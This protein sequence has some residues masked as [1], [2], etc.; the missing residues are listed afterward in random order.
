M[1]EPVHVNTI[2]SVSSSSPEPILTELPLVIVNRKGYHALQRQLKEHGQ[3]DVAYAVGV[4]ARQAQ[5]I[6]CFGGYYLPFT[7]REAL[8]A[9]CQSQGIPPELVIFLYRSN[10]LDFPHPDEPAS[11]TFDPGYRGKV[12][13]VRGLQSQGGPGERPLA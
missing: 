10:L 1:T 3:E 6:K 4:L 13:P 9:F 2:E 8:V 5:E 11:I 7:T 12:R